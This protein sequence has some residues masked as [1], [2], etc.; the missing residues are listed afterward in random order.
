MCSTRDVARWYDALKLEAS[1]AADPDHHL[2]REVNHATGNLVHRMFYWAELL[3]DR[4]PEDETREAVEHLK[5]SLGE[6]HRLITRTLDLVRAVEARPIQVGVPDLVRSVALRLGTEP[7][8]TDAPAVRE[9]LERCE[10]GVDPLLVERAVGLVAEALSL[11]PREG[12]SDVSVSPLHV[13]CSQ[14]P[15]A[16]PERQGLILHCVIRRVATASANVP[17]APVTDAVG[18]ALAR[19]LL[20]ALGWILDLDETADERSLVLFIPLSLEPELTTS[21]ALS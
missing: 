20:A 1:S 14:G 12:Q 8:W 3:G 16:S 21:I 5:G 4:P 9:A 17:A 11:Q 19:K 7:Q 2:M 13:R 10:L 6:L 18:I 15:D